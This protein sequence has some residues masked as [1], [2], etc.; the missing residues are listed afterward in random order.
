MLDSEPSPELTV[1]RVSSIYGDKCQDQMQCSNDAD[2]CTA[3]DTSKSGLGCMRQT[4]M[5][6]AVQE[7]CEGDSGQVWPD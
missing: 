3:L 4:S 2:N 6:N 1:A 7:D 5:C